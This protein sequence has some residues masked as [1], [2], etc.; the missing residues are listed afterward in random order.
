ML[1]RVIPI[2]LPAIVS[3]VVANPVIPLRRAANEQCLY[4]PFQGQANEENVIRDQYIVHFHPEHS[5]ELHKAHV[6]H[7]ISLKKGFKHLSWLPGYQA[8]MDNHTFHELVRRDPG[9]K[10]VENN[11]QFQVLADDEYVEEGPDVDNSNDPLHRRYESFVLP[12]APYNLQMVG[13]SGALPTPVSATGNYDVLRHAGAGVNICILDSGIR[14][15]HISFQG[16]ATNFQGMTNSPYANGDSMND[17]RGHGTG[18]AGV[19]G[20]RGYGVAPWATLVN[21]KVIRD[22]GTIDVA[23]VT[24]AINAVIDEHI[25]LNSQPHTP[26]VARLAWLEA[27]NRAAKAGIPV[28]A[29][30]GNDNVNAQTVY[31]CAFSVTGTTSVNC[32]AA[33]GLSNTYAKVDSSNVGDPVLVAAPGWQITSMGIAS[34]FA[35]TVRNGTS[36]AAAHVSGILATFIGFPNGEHPTRFA[37]NGI[38]YPGKD[39][40]APYNGGPVRPRVVPIVPGSEISAAIAGATTA[41]VGA[42]EASD[43][44]EIFA[45]ATI[46]WNDAFATTVTDTVSFT[47]EN[48]SSVSRDGFPSYAGSTL[49]TSPIVQSSTSG[50]GAVLTQVSAAATLSLPSPESS[51]AAG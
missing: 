47:L 1:Q 25:A 18:V 48:P 24:S 46:I 34:D 45:S 12:N 39:S 15:S 33:V 23:G 21:V 26:D 14:T 32:V 10:F 11:L 8:I 36:R 4:E 20:S 43:A 9:V 44:A 49:L 29:A 3:L 51:T 35:T 27:M 22:G 38:N 30:A 31:P 13:A 19:A 42:A 2:W 28:A 17:A 40:M 5:L 41:V 6:G 50:A 7:D 16:R 37:A